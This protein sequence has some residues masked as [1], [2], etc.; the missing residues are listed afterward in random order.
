LGYRHQRLR[1]EQWQVRASSGSAGEGRAATING[2]DGGGGDSGE[3]GVRDGDE[4]GVADGGDGGVRGSDE[5]GGGGTD[6]EAAIQQ[7][8]LAQLP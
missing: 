6:A 7:R 4:G 1:Q 3:R 8:F 5:S 2:V